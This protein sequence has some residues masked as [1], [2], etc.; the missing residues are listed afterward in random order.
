MLGGVL[1]ARVMVVGLVFGV[2]IG[3]VVTLLLL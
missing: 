3:A 1:K 2:L